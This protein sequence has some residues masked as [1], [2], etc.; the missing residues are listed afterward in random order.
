MATNVTS[1]T[2]SYQLIGAGSHALELRGSGK[3]RLHFGASP[4]S[5]S[6]NAYITLE[7]NSQAHVGDRDSYFHAF[8]SNIYARLDEGQS[9]VDLISIN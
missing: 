8:T 5:D 9:A 1:L 3:V 7:S 6:T 4:P 2:S